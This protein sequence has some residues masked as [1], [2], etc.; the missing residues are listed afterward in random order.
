[1]CPEFARR[2][3]AGSL[4]HGAL[5]SMT[6]LVKATPRVLPLA[7]G[8]LLVGRGITRS[9]RVSPMTLPSQALCFGDRAVAS[10]S[11]NVVASCARAGVGFCCE[12]PVEEHKQ[13]NNETPGTTCRRSGHLSIAAA[14][15]LRPGPGTLSFSRV[16]VTGMCRRIIASPASLGLCFRIAVSAIVRRLFAGRP[17]VAASTSRGDVARCVPHVRGRAR[18]LGDIAADLVRRHVV[19]RAL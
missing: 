1:M 5:T 18:R 16:A 13:G 10:M 9:A 17:A 6:G 4:G 11:L 8:M 15:R 19:A 14:A 7:I 2:C 12:E 3:V